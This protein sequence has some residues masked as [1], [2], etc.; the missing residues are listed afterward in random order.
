[1]YR[2]PEEDWWQRTERDR[3]KIEAYDRAHPPRTRSV[4]DVLVE[5]V[6]NGLDPVIRE[7]P[8]SLRQKARAAI[9]AGIEAGTEK[10]IDSAIDA[11]GVTGDAA[12]AL[13]AA[14]KEA[15]KSKPSGGTR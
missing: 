5:G 12:Q 15:L 2:P 8:K 9:R 1:M 11:S 14:C 6:T 10:A 4:T 3:R 7:L 13:K